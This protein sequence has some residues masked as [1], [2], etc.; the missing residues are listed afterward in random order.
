METPPIDTTTLGVIFFEDFNDNKNNWT[1][2]D[3]KKGSARM[4]PVRGAVFL[5]MKHNNSHTAL[6]VI[7]KLKS[8]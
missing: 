5:Q 2:A 8:L 3:N 6:S 1:I 7:V 4:E